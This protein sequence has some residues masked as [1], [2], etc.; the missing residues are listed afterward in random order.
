VTALPTSSTPAAPAPPTSPAR[1][2]DLTS[3]F[4]LE[5]VDDAVWVGLSDRLHLP[6][7]YGG[8]LVGQ[9][10]MAA[11]RSI[12]PEMRIHSSHTSFLRPGTPGRPIRY[13]VEDVT[14]GRR[15]GVRDVSAWQED[16]L[17]CRTI[18]SATVEDESGIQHARSAPVVGPPAE[19]VPLADLAES[20]AGLGPW[21]E[22]FE[23][24]EVRVD[25]RD[26]RPDAPHSAVTPALLWMRTTEPL[27]SD[28]LFHRA[29]LAYTSDLMLMATAAAAHG[30][31]VGHESRLAESFW[32]IS[33]DHTLWYQ[34]DLAADEWLLFEQVSPMA[35]AGH[36]LIQSTVF[37]PSGRPVGHVSQ[38]ALLR[39]Q[40]P[41]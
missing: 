4:D 13:Q 3:L 19:A 28:P 11:G 37:D 8:Q 14:S 35:E 16:R 22:Q 34:G 41:G 21:W 36:T 31:P 33:L 27:P 20:G 29:A 1:Q 12:G 18:V 10:V 2:S 17:L 30:I 25:Q 38:E 15:R 7:L 6:Q 23:A 26:P 40:R 9:S 32:G 24:I 5:R 39:P